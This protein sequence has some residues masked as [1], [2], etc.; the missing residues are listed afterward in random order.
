MQNGWNGNEQRGYVE[1]PQNHLSKYIGTE[2][3]AA[4]A[5]AG[6][7][8]RNF[9]AIPD[10][11]GHGEPQESHKNVR[12]LQ[13][14]PAP[15][16]LLTPEGWVDGESLPD[17]RGPARIA[18]AQGERGAVPSVHAGLSPESGRATGDTAVRGL[19]EGS[20]RART[21]ESEAAHQEAQHR[22]DIDRRGMADGPG[23]AREPLCVLWSDGSITDYRSRHSD[24]QGRESHE[25]QRSAGVPS[26]QQSEEGQ[27]PLTQWWLLGPE[28][29]TE[30]HYAAFPTE[31]PKRCILAGSRK[32]D[33]VLDPFLGSGTTALVADRLERNAIGIELSPTYA[34]MARRR[35]TNDA[36]MFADVALTAGAGDARGTRAG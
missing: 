21:S 11:I 3:G 15:R 10:T 26:L 31:I 27:A 24:Q 28:P 5:A 30:E 22:D 8:L 14:D 17:L 34:E 12:G 29:S 1:G 19:P 9:W 33:T 35:V 18:G 7:N 16:F 25:G 36:P 20:G 2:R 23:A 6:A 4:M 13:D 32:G